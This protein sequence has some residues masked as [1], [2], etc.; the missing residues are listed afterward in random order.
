MAQF[1]EP[2]CFTFANR[3]I[4]ALCLGHVEGP[5]GLGA[6]GTALIGGFTHV[7]RIL[8]ARKHALE[9]QYPM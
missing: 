3:R 5:S 2:P 7:S 1:A 6:D 9:P 8:R 4:S